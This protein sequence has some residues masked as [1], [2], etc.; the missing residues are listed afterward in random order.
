MS[1]DRQ[2]E[3]TTL[4]ERVFA[5]AP[6]QAMQPEPRLLR[7][8]YDWL[9]AGEVAQRT[10]ARLSEQLRRYL[11]DQVFLENRRIMR[12][13]RD[14]EQRAIAVRDRPPAGP[15]AEIDECAPQIEL[16]VALPPGVASQ[17][18][19]DEVLVCTAQGEVLYEWQ[20]A[21]PDLWVSFFEF[22]SQRGQRLAQTLPLGEFNRLEIQ[23]GGVRAVVIITNDRGILVFLRSNGVH[24]EIAVPIKTDEMDWGTE[25]YQPFVTYGGARPSFVS[26][27]WGD[28]QFYV[29]T[30]RFREMRP[31]SALSALAG[32]NGSVIHAEHIPGPSSARGDATMVLSPQQ[33]RRLAGYIRDSLQR[34][35]SG[36][37]ILATDDNFGHGDRFFVARGSYGPVST[38]NEWV[39]RGLAAAGVRTAAWAPLDWALFWHAR[40]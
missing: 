28:A 13:L 5:L 14:I 31:W 33:Y 30:R 37:V 26:F 25:L 20:C 8:H 11:D 32:R 16:P 27:G 17:P 6:V 19:V 3:F 35:P 10:V 18:K 34:T 2:E 24:A 21:H 38:C 7:V 36:L 23:S 22:V 40:R 12:I 39:R 29:E 1:P 9:E 15:F 4:I